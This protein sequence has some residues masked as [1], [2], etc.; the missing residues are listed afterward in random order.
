MDNLRR[1]GL[2][3]EAVASDAGTVVQDVDKR[4][5]L[6][7]RDLERLEKKLDELLARRW[8]LWKLVLAAF[9]GSILTV[10]GSFA[11]KSLDHYVGVGSAPAVPISGRK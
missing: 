1:D 2:R 9:L 8:E 3:V 6:A 7:V 4:L 11:I 5:A 10:V